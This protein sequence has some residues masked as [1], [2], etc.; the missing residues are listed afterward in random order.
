[1]RWTDITL[2][3][4]VSLVKLEREPDKR[5]VKDAVS[6]MRAAA[7][8]PMATAVAAM[9]PQASLERRRRAADGSHYQQQQNQE[10]EAEEGA[11]LLPAAPPLS[12]SDFLLS[13][14]ASGDKE[15]DEE[16][17][18]QGSAFPAWDAAAKPPAV[19]LAA[20]SSPP[21]PRR[22]T[23]DGGAAAAEAAADGGSCGGGGQPH[24]ELARFLASRVSQ[25]LSQK[26]ATLAAALVARGMTSRAELECAAEVVFG[27]ENSAAVAPS[28][29]HGVVGWRP[30]SFADS[31]WREREQVR[32]E[33]PPSFL[34]IRTRRQKSTQQAG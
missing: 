14:A 3:S 15:G 7:A 34:L 22:T 29:Q 12:H 27:E 19:P 11:E 21:P 26:A 32:C 13:E 5:A 2:L 8:T 23:R 33:I 10:K 28:S 9:P 16:R 4:Q 25:K 6:A 31:N 24:E 30:Q 20:A 17:G 1:M 18:D